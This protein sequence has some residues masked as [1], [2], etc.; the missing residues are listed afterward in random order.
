MN[1]AALFARGGETSQSGGGGARI[2]RA[3]GGSGGT[4]IST[5]IFNLKRRSPGNTGYG[6]DGV[7]GSRVRGGAGGGDVG[8]WDGGRGLLGVVYRLVYS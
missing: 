2:I 3:K 1:P 4:A 8:L 5:A 6:R 7:R